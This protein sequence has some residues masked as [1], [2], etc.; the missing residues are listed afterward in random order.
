M[1]NAKF[2][3]RV[4][5]GLRA[6]TKDDHVSKRYIL[7]IGQNKSKFYIAQKLL[8]KSLFKEENLFRYLNCF[9]FREESTIKCGIYEFARC[10]SLMKSVKK[11]PAIVFSRYGASILSITSIDGMTKFTPTTLS[12]YG[13]FRDRKDADKFRDRT[14]FYYIK[15]GYIYLPDSEIEM[16]NIVYIPF[17]ESKVNAASECSDEDNCKSIWDMEFIVPDKLSEQVITETINEVSQSKG[18]PIDENPNLDSNIKSS[19]TR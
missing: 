3:S 2:V 7:G 16:V 12:N 17:D 18:I 13:L 1:T 5:N 19:T 11:V 14:R 9:K 4:V 10:E 8:D 15:D 6:L